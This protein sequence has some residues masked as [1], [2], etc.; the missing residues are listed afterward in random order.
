MGKTAIAIQLAQY[1][2]TEIISADS[3]QCYKE[4]NIG[5]AKP[6][7]QELQT[8]PHHFI[9]YLSIT[10]EFNAADYEKYATEKINAI[11]KKNDVAIVTGG[12]GLYISAFT[13]G[14]NTI[15]EVELTLRTQLRKTYHEQGID[16]LLSQLKMHDAAYLRGNHMN[17][18][19]R[20]LRALEVKLSTGKSILSF[21]QKI[22]KQH[23]FAI[24]SVCLQQDR[25]VLIERINSRVDQMI[26]D[27]LVTEVEA[28]Q[29]YQ[30]LN[31]LQTVGYKEIFNYLNRQCSLQQAIEQIKINTRRYAKRQ[32]TWFSKVKNM[33]MVPPDYH[34]ILHYILLQQKNTDN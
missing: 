33:V 21:Q 5:V 25:T 24:I 9:N 34:H 18:P 4:L 17:N 15:P 28:L 16:W 32:V 23:S 6:T 3:R 22:D 8:V 19:Q 14:L 11:F 31:A 27:G 20:L 30:H 12:T 26:E 29:A 1:F 2:N 13:D 10:D 7:A